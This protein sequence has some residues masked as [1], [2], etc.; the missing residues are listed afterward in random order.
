MSQN[1]PG[2]ADSTLRP[3]GRTLG[4]REFLV[5]YVSDKQRRAIEFS[6]LLISCELKVLP[7]LTGRCDW[8]QPFTQVFRGKVQSS[9]TRPLRTVGCNV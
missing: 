1:R 2:E 6:L 5:L 7:Y 4:E 9:A 8:S 3:M